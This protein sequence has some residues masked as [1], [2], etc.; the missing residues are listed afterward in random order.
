MNP[1]ILPN[2]SEQEV[3]DKW[4]KEW[5]KAL[6]E[7]SPDLVYHRLRS[8]LDN[9]IESVGNSFDPKTD[10]LY[11][12]AESCFINDFDDLAAGALFGMIHFWEPLSPLSES[13]LNLFRKRIEKI[14]RNPRKKM[15]NCFFRKSNRCEQDEFSELVNDIIDLNCEE[16]SSLVSKLFTSW[17]IPDTTEF[18][19]IK[20]ESITQ[21]NRFERI[22][23]SF[24]AFQAQYMSVVKFSFPCEDPPACNM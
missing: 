16:M 10:T 9:I 18:R 4:L 20:C 21:H 11:M 7:K 13:Q 1:L 15:F 3:V 17:S 19:K 23:A 14:C 2:T 22:S 5:A 12:L 6:S 24:S 8:C